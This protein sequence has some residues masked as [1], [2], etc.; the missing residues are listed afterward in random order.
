MKAIVV[1]LDGTLCDVSHRV[2]L[3]DA[4]SKNEFNA[5]MVNDKLNNWCFEIIQ[6][7]WRTHEIL[8]V[9]TRP[10]KYR[11]LTEKWLKKNAVEYDQL[12]MRDNYEISNVDTKQ[13][14][15]DVFIKGKYSVEF[16]LEDRKGA[17]E[18]WRRNGLICLQCADNQF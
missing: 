7:F 16:V 11:N 6:R 9:T 3:A 13:E 4:A 18:M 2:D 14:I 1:D 17:T 15:F 5:L 8:L 10:E 12:Y